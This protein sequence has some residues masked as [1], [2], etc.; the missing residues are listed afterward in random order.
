MCHMQHLCIYWYNDNA[1]F[2]SVSVFIFGLFCKCSIF[3]PF[4]DSC[5]LFVKSII[6]FVSKLIVFVVCF[7]KYLKNFFM[8][9][10]PLYTTC[11]FFISSYCPYRRGSISAGN[12]FTFFWC[13]RF[14]RIIFTS[15]YFVNLRFKIPVNNR[16]CL[17]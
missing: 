11:L 15:V 16:Y 4:H 12:M 9:S 1:I 10:S 13:G 8:Q 17:C 6:F 2:F 3:W 14:F 7:P 5:S